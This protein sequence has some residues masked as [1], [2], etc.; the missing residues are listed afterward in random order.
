VRTWRLAELQAKRGLR[1]STR[2]EA[3]RRGFAVRFSLHL[4]EYLAEATSLAESKE[5][6]HGTG[7]AIFFARLVGGSEWHA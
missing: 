6:R 5:G 4:L 2:I 7:S 3:D 1:G